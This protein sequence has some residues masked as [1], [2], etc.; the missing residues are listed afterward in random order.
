MMFF[1]FIY[2]VLSSEFGNQ[3]KHSENIF[4]KISKSWHLAA[5]VPMNIKIVH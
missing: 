1:V 3:R 4:Q 2:V 5:S